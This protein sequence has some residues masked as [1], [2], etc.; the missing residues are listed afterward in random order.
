MSE[1]KKPNQ[2][3]LDRILFD[4]TF[5]ELRT[6]AKED[7][8]NLG[9]YILEARRKFKLSPYWN[10]MLG[11]LLTHDKLVENFPFTGASID[12]RK[13]ATTGKDYY[14]IPVY[15]ET[16][17]ENI[18]SSAKNIR[19]YYKDRGE[20]IDIRS[21]DLIKTLTE[22]RTLELHEAGKSNPEILEVLEQEFEEAYI[23]N[24]I[25]ILIRSA[26]QKSMR[27]ENIS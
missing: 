17:N 5:R 25:P 6:K 8:S 1:N 27:E 20:I 9:E 2:K 21:D 13:D 12:S 7:S 22:F 15:P 24:D 19:Q 4:H 23:I 26:K 11:F 10:E 16:T 3:I 14:L 18:L